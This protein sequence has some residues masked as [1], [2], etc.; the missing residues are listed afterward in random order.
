M[1]NE[2][3]RWESL[4]IPLNDGMT[5]L[6]IH[7][8]FNTYSSFLILIQQCGLFGQGQGV[9]ELVEVSLHD[10]VYLL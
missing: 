10:L 7:Q 9:D 1:R 8:D 2:E 3:L 6:Q 5:V 4:R